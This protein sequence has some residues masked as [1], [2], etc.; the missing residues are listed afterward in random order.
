VGKGSYLLI[1]GNS[2]L[3]LD[4]LLDIINGITRLD[5]KGNGLTRESLDLYEKEVRRKNELHATGN[6]GLG[7]GQGENSNFARRSALMAAL[8]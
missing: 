1:R 4:L 2:F 3:V 5:L 6:D 8:V 7:S